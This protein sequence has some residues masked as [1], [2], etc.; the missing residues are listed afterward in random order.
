MG[1][2]EKGKDKIDEDSEEF[3]LMGE[4]ERLEEEDSD[5]MQDIY[6][7]RTKRNAPDLPLAPVSKRP[8]K[9]KFIDDECSET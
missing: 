3:N 5:F 4:L 9:N 6:K 7:E 2:G 8:R 1:E